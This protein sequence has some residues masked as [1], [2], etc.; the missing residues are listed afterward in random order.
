MR[1]LGRPRAK[2]GV[3]EVRRPSMLASWGTII[4]ERGKPL[5]REFANKLPERARAYFE[6]S[7]EDSKADAVPEA[8]GSVATAGSGEVF[9]YSYF[10]CGLDVTCSAEGWMYPWAAIE[11]EWFRETNVYVGSIYDACLSEV[12]CDFF[13]Y[14]NPTSTREGD[15]VQIHSYVPFFISGCDC[16]SGSGWCS[17]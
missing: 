3:K 8:E 14:Y 2:L 10:H 7:L 9:E 13:T 4:C 6:R 12:P 15:Y 5:S 1:K 11:V 17:Y 16:W